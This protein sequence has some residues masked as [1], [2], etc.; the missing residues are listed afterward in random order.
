MS[1]W[2]RISCH[3]GHKFH[4]S[5]TFLSFKTRIELN[6]FQSWPQSSANFPSLLFQLLQYSRQRSSFS[7]H[8]AALMTK[9][10][11]FSSIFFKICR[12]RNSVLLSLQV[13]IPRGATHE[14]SLTVVW[15]SWTNQNS[16]A[17]HSNQ[18][19]CFIC[20]DN[21]LRHMA[22]FVFVKVSGAE[23]TS[24]LSSHVERFR[25][26]KVFCVSVC[27]L[28]YKTNR[29]HVGKCGKNISDR[30]SYRILTSS[31]IY[32]WTDARQHGI[33]LLIC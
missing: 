6:D 28:L 23:W 3:R 15:F 1:K 30:L 19:D 5:L 16:L 18:W 12:F 13:F 14:S 9:T 25:N 20:I 29:F 21:R 33:Y 26:K 4:P 24:S 7:A 11:Y 22:F 8:R 17:F 32:Y 31:L 27:F 10:V 2:L